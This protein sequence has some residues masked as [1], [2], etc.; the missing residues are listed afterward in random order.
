MPA[1]K[2]ATHYGRRAEIV[3]LQ[4]LSKRAGWGQREGGSQDRSQESGI[5]GIGGGSLVSLL[6]CGGFSAAFVSLGLRLS[7]RVQ[8]QRQL[9]IS[10]AVF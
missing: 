1:K 2:R 6:E 8:D 4:S 3:N 7:C 5:R 9:W 10:L